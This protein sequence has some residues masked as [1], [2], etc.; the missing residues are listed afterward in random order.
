MRWGGVRF[1]LLL[2]EGQQD[3]PARSWQGRLLVPSSL[4]WGRFAS[5]AREGG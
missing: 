4:E 1:W 5:F 3:T 2:T